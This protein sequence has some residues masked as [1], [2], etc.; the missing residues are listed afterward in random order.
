MFGG[1][2]Y[3]SFALIVFLLDRG[4]CHRVGSQS[5]STFYNLNLN[6][7]AKF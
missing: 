2:L 3:G 6:V 5:F 4:F 7:E 1:V